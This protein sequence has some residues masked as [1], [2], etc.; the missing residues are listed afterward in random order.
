MAF[1]MYD[2]SCKNMFE[3]ML[4]I[5]AIPIFSSKNTGVRYESV[6]S[7]NTIKQSATAITT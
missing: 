5:I 3:P 2:T 7:V 4:Y 1:V 6:A